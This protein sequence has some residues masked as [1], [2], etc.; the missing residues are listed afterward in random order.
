MWTG[1]AVSVF[2]LILG[3]TGSIVEWAPELTR[4]QKQPL[5]A[6]AGA[7]AIPVGELVA[8]VQKASPGAPLMVVNLGG[9]RTDPYSFIVRESAPKRGRS[10]VRF[11]TV[12][13]YTGEIIKSQTPEENARNSR[14]ADRFMGET[15]A[16]HKNLWAG[17]TG[18]TIVNYSTLVGIFLILTG[19]ILWWPRKIWWITKGA[20]WR[21]LNFDLHSVAGF[22]SM[23]FFLIISITGMMV[24]WGQI[25]R[26]I[27]QLAGQQRPAPA[28]AP[29]RIPA[30]AGARPLSLEELLA[31]ADTLP[32]AS[33]TSVRFGQHPG[34]PVTVLRRSA[35]SDG[36][37]IQVSLDPFTGA[38][39][40]TNDPAA[41]PWAVRLVRN[42]VPI[43]DG[44]LFGMPGR[45]IATITSTA[46]PV[47]VITGFIIWW[48][49]K[50]TEWKRRWAKHRGRPLA[51]K[52]LEEELET[53]REGLDRAVRSPELV[54]GD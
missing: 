41:Q 23:I 45:I 26:T 34:E 20:S 9:E 18:L 11:Y 7:K 5:A 47:M 30:P 42:T 22:Y 28:A 2:L 16:L 24:H 13:Q 54:A 27:I 32:G 33:T 29:R 49:R 44:T 50:T 52:D 39:L 19:L 8:T 25:G 4:T 46:V 43:H 17:N 51:V 1:L 36:R 53:K 15:L 40:A 48:K 12:N 35:A 3:V 37:T 21:R 31:K 14:F 38:T 10:G 6:P